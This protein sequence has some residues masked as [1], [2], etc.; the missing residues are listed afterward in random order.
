[1]ATTTTTTSGASTVPLAA[2]PSPIV[3][4]GGFE[5]DDEFEEFEEDGEFAQV[6][7]MALVYSHADWTDFDKM[8]LAETDWPAAD[9][10]A[11]EDEW[12]EDWDDDLVEGDFVTQ[13]RQ[14]LQ[15]TSNQGK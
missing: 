8:T 13:L 9:D 3:E 7:Q 5:E 11:R 15:S 12:D 2:E 14:E 10:A 1:M 6:N 4:A